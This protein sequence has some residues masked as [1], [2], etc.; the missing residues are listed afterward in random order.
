[1]DCLSYF[2]APFRPF[3]CKN[4]YFIIIRTVQS[5]EYP[6]LRNNVHL[7]DPLPRKQLITNILHDY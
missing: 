3:K 1:M 5:A 6:Q 4:S 2:Y 7:H